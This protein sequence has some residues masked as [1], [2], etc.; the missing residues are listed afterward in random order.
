MHPIAFVVMGFGAFLALV[1]I[2]LFS[3][4]GAEGTSSLKLL[5]L[6]FNLGGSSLV[7]FV[8]G[9]VLV[10]LP[11]I[12]KGDFPTV[13]TATQDITSMQGDFVGTVEAM[14]GAETLPPYPLRV[15]LRITGAVVGGE[16]DNDSGDKGVLTGTI[17][18]NSLD[19]HLVSF[20]MGGDCSLKGNLIDAGR[21]LSAI[22]RCPDGEHGRF[23]LARK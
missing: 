7:I 8:L 22:Y 1:G 9:F 18:G 15:T 13:M 10:I 21:K 23:N 20:V 4:R 11:F 17:D 14:K 16:Y 12:R 3:K 2:V 5:G 19:L 6:E